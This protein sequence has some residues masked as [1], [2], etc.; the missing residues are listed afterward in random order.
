VGDVA[1]DEQGVEAVVFDFG[2]V[3]IT[4]ITNQLG[5]VAVDH[6][7]PV[8]TMKA[9]LMGPSESGDHPWHRAERGEIAVADIQAD[10]QRWAGPYDV[11]LA[12]DEIARLLAPGKYSVVH[13][14]HDRVSELRRRGFRTGLL[15]NTF[16]EFQ[17][18]MQRDLDFARF[19]VV[20]ESFAVGARKPEPE[21]YEA[22][23]RALG[24][25]G[26]SILYLDD[27]AE[28]LTEPSRRGW[29]IMHV[30]DPVD[31]VDRLDRRLA[32]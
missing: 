22:T 20:V 26:S 12:G 31:A 4:S 8:A 14:M 10:L 9:V 1:S 24:L 16:L 15:T 30:T 29:Q 25:S 5:E 28:N 27:F 23:E 13:R 3:L 7:V 32:G 19:D 21:I 6:G 2:G 18:T 17:P 11:Q